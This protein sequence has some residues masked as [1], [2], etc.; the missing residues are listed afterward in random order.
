MG[1]GCAQA[2]AARRAAGSVL[3]PA[4]VLCGTLPPTP[5]HRGL[6]F[7][8]INDVM[9][10]TCSATPLHIHRSIPYPHPTPPHAPRHPPPTCRHL[11]LAFQ[12]IDDV[13][14]FTC[15][16]A[17]M[18]KPA[19]NDLRSGLATAPTLFAAEEH[20]ELL[21]LIKRRFKQVRAGETCC[22]WRLAPT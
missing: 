11:G 3:L 21:P 15:S 5:R 1:W 22:S 13:M 4:S 7:Q 16:A 10:V 12:I 17:E 20:S 18:G 2:Q 19:L 14:D 6:A 8:I 9:D